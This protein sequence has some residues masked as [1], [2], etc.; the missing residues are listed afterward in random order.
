MYSMVDIVIPETFIPEDVKENFQSENY[1]LININLNLP[2]EGGDIT[3]DSLNQIKTK[4]S[5][6]YDK[7]Y[8]TGGNQPYIQIYKRLQLRILGM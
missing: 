6:Y 7:W 3:K 4:V 1:S 5:N 2:M 8:L